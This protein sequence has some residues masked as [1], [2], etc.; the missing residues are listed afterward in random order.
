MKP[1]KLVTSEPSTNIE[2]CEPSET[3][4]PAESIEPTG[5]E[6]LEWGS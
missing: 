4:D 1:V 6:V 5:T 3:G 2:P